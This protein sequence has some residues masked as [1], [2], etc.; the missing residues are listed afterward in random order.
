MQRNLL[1]VPSI[2]GRVQSPQPWHSQSRRPMSWPD[3]SYGLSWH[4]DWLVCIDQ[5]ETQ[6]G[7]T[8]M[9]DT[10]GPAFIA[11]TLGMIV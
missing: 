11:F 9:A 7:E 5:Q 6:I 3:G 1:N 8:D 4:R 2:D 10:S